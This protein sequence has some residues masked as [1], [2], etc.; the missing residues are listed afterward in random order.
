MAP[1][2]LASFLKAKSV[3]EGVEWFREHAAIAALLDLRADPDP[4]KVVISHHPDQLRRVE[5]GYG[6]ATKPT[7]YLDGFRA[8]IANNLNKI[9]ALT[10]VTQRPRDLTRAELKALRLA[11]DNAGY[12]ETA[13]RTAWRDATNADIAAS[14]IGFIR[15]AALGD[16]LLPY[17]DRVARAMTNILASRPWTGPQRKWLERIGKQLVNEIVV[18]R[19][20]LDSGS[21][22]RTVALT[23]STR[24]STASLRPSWARSTKPCGR[25]RDDVLSNHGS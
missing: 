10:V 19:A 18:D 20:A 8:F 23:A 9:A 21:S 2:A 11:L 13:L 6:D 22:R 5:R 12:S 14:I 24:C 15:Q 17:E 3:D 1:H 4:V 7:D 16:P 25:R